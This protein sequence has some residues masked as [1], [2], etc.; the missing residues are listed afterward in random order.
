MN[1]YYFLI[2]IFALLFTALSIKRLDFALAFIL[3]ALPS[4]LLRFKVFFIPFTLLE[5]MIIILFLVWFLKRIFSGEKVYLGKFRYLI[6]LWLAVA[7]LAVIVSPNKISALGIWKA[8]FLEPVLFFFVFINEI[9]DKKDLELVLTALGAGALI[10]SLIAFYQ[11]FTGW[12]VPYQYW[13][14]GEGRRVTGVFPYPNALALYLGPI[15]GLLLGRIFKGGWE[16]KKFFY[17]IVLFFSFLAIVFA[18]S[19]GAIAALVLSLFVFGL[20]F[21]KYRLKTILIILILIILFTTIPLFREY[22]INKFNGQDWSVKVRLT[23]WQESWQMLKD[24]W[25]FGAGLAGYQKK[26]VPYHQAKYI[27]IFLYPH[28]IF[29]NFWSELGLFGLLT[30]LLLLLKSFKEVKKKLIVKNNFFALSCLLALLI[31]IF[32]GLVD[33]PYFKNDLSLLFWLIIGLI[34]LKI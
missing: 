18:R 28:N 15:I 5:L 33:V 3:F 30:F 29:L 12:L 8:Y 34:N 31:I 4:Y 11:K 9:K 14:K 23:L 10:V 16:K 24:N 17:L 13:F 25:L 20:S 6:F 7:S 22:L 32:H 21:K 26:I 19:E 1:T 27:E 2:F